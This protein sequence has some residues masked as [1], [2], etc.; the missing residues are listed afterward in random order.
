MLIAKNINKVY[1][2]I[3]TP[4]A[5]PD[6]LDKSYY[7]SLDGWRAL[8]IIIVI[9]G[10]AKL[11]FETT[12]DTYKF[13]DKVIY[14][15]LGVRIFFVLSGFLISSLLIKEFIKTGKINIKFFFIKRILR[16]FPVLYLYLFVIFIL[17]IVLDLNLNYQHLIGPLLYVNNFSFFNGT[18]LTGHTWSLAVEEQFYLIWPF[19]FSFTPKKMCI[20]CSVLI[21]F[22]P[23]LKIF[24]YLFPHFQEL[25]LSPFLGNAD[26]I[27]T[28]CL[29]SFLSF[30]GFFN[31]K[32]QIWR[33]GFLIP[34]AIVSVEC[35]YFFQSQGL[36]GKFLLP[37][38]NLIAN[39]LIALSLIYSLVICNS[40]TYKI[41]NLKYVVSLGTVSYGLYIWQQLFIVPIH[42]YNDKFDM[43][44][45]PMNIIIAIGVAYISFHFYEK[46][47]LILKKNYLL[48]K[49]TV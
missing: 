18:W 5:T 35:I 28:G 45:A 10:H 31:K 34:F 40:L 44:T 24:W 39:I 19:L 9:L 36:Y 27:F 47:F 4:F 38:G 26:A 13:A 23:L 21:L 43:L 15:N 3:I 32:Q 41:L 46:Y 14:A 1:S 12:S 37:F 16:I 17:N 20:I 2:K 48:K 30:K 6:F 42:T 7:P 25:T 29:F 49:E 11:T 33:N 8:A 22:I